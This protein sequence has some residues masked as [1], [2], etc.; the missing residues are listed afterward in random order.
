MLR[1]LARMARRSGDEALS[2]DINF[3]A[4][5]ARTCKGCSTTINPDEAAVHLPNPAG[6]GVTGPYHLRCVGK[7]KA[8]AAEA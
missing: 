5:R 1:Q 7:A 6:R 4:S 3:V 8:E 2:S